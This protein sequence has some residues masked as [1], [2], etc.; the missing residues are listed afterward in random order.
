LRQPPP[1]PNPAATETPRYQTLPLP[2]PAATKTPRYQT[3]PLPNPGAQESHL[4]SHVNAHS[5][6]QPRLSTPLLAPTN[7]QVYLLVP[8][9]HHLTP[10]SHHLTPCKS[11]LPARAYRLAP[12]QVAGTSSRYQLYHTLS[13]PKRNIPRTYQRVGTSS[14]LPT[15][16]IHLAATGCHCYQLTLTAS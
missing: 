8:R 15:R 1:L 3:P 12:R 10:C 9:C 5:Y 16:A 14:C 11:Q 6:Q 13:N 4:N 2:N 7:S